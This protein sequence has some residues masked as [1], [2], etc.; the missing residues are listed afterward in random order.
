[1][2]W[3]QHR[4]RP[5]AERPFH[6]GD[7]CPQLTLVVHVEGQA[8]G[9][10]LGLAGAAGGLDRHRVAQLGGGGGR[11]VGVRRQPGAHQGHASGAERAERHRRGHLPGPALAQDTGQAPAHLVGRR[12]SAGSSTSPSGA[13]R[14][15]A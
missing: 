8:G 6:A 4:P 15:W 1:M 9:L 11:G 14:H 13:S 5:L 10:G 2:N 12:G 7:G 3:T